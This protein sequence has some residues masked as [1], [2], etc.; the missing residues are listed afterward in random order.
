MNRLPALLKLIVL[1]W[2]VHAE[3]TA[4]YAP[5]EVLA[6]ITP[7]FSKE[8]PLL[9]SEAFAGNVRSIIK[10][11]LPPSPNTE[12]FLLHDAKKGAKITVPADT[13]STDKKSCLFIFSIFTFQI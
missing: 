7:L 6:T 8:P 9:L 5:A 12:L 2:C 10:S 4:M 3:E 1:P 13:P 11:T